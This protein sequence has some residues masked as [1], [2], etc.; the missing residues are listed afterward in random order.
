MDRCMYPI[1]FILDSL[2][3]DVRRFNTTIE[4]GAQDSLESARIGDCVRTADGSKTR[5]YITAG[6]A[7]LGLGILSVAAIRGL[8]S[9]SGVN[10]TESRSETLSCHYMTV[11]LVRGKLLPGPPGVEQAANV[12]CTTKMLQ[13]SLLCQEQCASVAP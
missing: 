5:E 10:S 12:P 3:N 1:S 2:R 9:T 13:T 4:T 11:S 8:D 6:L 7:V